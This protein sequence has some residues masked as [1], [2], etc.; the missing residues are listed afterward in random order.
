MGFSTGDRSDLVNQCEWHAKVVR[1]GSCAFRA[2]RIRAHH[3]GLLIVWNLMLNIFS[4]QMTSIEVVYGNVKEPLVLR[5]VKIHCDNMI[6]TSTSQQVGNQGT[7]LSYPLAIASL[8]FE[9]RWL[10]SLL[11]SSKLG[12]KTRRMDMTDLEVTLIG[13]AATSTLGW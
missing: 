9:D 10:C 1:D 4:E 11:S 6:R 2:A 3:N 8:G 12:G 7:R 5:I 13:L